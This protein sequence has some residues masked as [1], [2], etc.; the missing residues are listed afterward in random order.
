M[1]YILSYPL[2]E[3]F[4]NSWPSKL[5]LIIFVEKDVFNYELKELV[6]K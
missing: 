2:A 1:P 3:T 5:F 6:M 4:L